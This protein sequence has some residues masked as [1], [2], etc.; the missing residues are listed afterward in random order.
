MTSLSKMCMLTA[1]VAAMLPSVAMGNDAHSSEIL[2]LYGADSTKNNEMSVRYAG[3]YVT[4]SYYN[5]AIANYSL[6]QMNQALPQIVDPWAVQV[7]HEMSA[8]MNAHAKRQ[9]LLSVVIIK[10]NNINAFAV[11]G[12]LIGINAGVISAAESMDEVASV[13]AHEI[14]HLSLRHY[15]R[16]SEDKGKLMAMQIGGLLAA[17]AASSA[18]GDA[19]AA[20]MIGSQTLS[21]ES[22]AKN[23]RAHEREAD[24]VGMQIL[25]AAGYDARAMPRFFDTLQQKIKI[26]QHKSSYLPSFAQSHPFTL[27]RLSEASSRASHYPVPT[28]HSQVRQKTLFD[29]LL[30]RVR[31]LNYVSEEELKQASKV[32]QGAKLAYSAYLVDKRRFD[33]AQ[34][35][36]DGVDKTLQSEPLYCITEGHILYEKGDFKTAAQVLSACHAIYPERRDLTVYLADSLIYADDAARAIQL[37]TPLSAVRHDLVVW[38]LLQRA[39]EVQAR[40][41]PHLKDTFTAYALYARANKQMWRGQ[42]EGALVSLAQAKSLAGHALP[43]ITKINELT[44]DVKSYRDFKP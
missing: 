39:Y 9:D 12:G 43:L 32:S 34:N 44:E 2:S 36:F 20:M 13:L 4:D 17:I 7:I 28:S 19:A 22:Q 27:E 14:A 8:D 31:Y 1:L 33:E 11:P 40:Q 16:S 3:D 21:M 6:Q 18:S 38:D 29:L 35:V 10:D 30:W 25:S 26:N 37:L 41:Q 23:S 15:E 24:R 42:F 5:R